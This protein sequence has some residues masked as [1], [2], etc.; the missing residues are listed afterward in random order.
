MCDPAYPI[1]TE[2]SWQKTKNVKKCAKSPKSMWGVRGPRTENRDVQ[3]PIFSGLIGLL[4]LLGL[5][6]HE[7]NP[8]QPS[9]LIKSF[10]LKK[11]FNHTPVLSQLIT[12]ISAQNAR[13]TLTGTNDPGATGVVR[14]LLYQNSRGHSL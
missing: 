3:T 2:N 4:G 5:S 14:V 12:S 8:T 9:R 7:A 11:S 13:A 6:G 10:Q 1:Y